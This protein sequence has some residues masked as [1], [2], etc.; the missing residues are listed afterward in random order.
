MN[1]KLER[2]LAELLDAD[3]ITSETAQK[4]STFYGTKEDAK[5]NRLFAI[6]GVLGALLCGLG[7]ILIIA[8]NWDDMPKTMKT[9]LAFI[10]LIIGQIATVYSLIK[11]KNGAWVESS[12]TFLI[13]AAG[14]TI[15]LVSQI[16]NIPGDLSNFLLVW[17]VITAPLIYL[18]RSNLAV[19][20]HL[21]LITCYACNFGY[22]F[23][24]QVPWWYLPLTAWVIPYYIKLQ[25]DNPKSNIAGVLNWL[26]PLSL[27]IV[28]PTFSNGSELVFVMYIGLFGLF[29]NIG[30]LPLFNNQKLRR[31][32]FT[33]IGSLGTVY[34]LTLLTFKWFWTD[35]LHGVI[36]TNDLLISILLFATAI[37]V[38]WYVQM[39]NQLKDFNLFQY[40]FLIFGVLY[41]TK[42]LGSI[43][44]II[45]TNILVAALGLFAVRIGINKNSYGILNYGLLII[46][47]LIACRFF[48]TNLDFV[49][50]GILFIS[51]G[52]GFFFANYLLLKKQRKITSN[53]KATNHE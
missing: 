24:G 15:S 8:H 48:D 17:A 44:G 43:H 21:V 52:A 1:S 26:I 9:V 46:T 29:Y 37:A 40:A 41:L 10:P 39:K 47:A 45:I 14:A 32:G 28:L 31:N 23:G 42:D 51:V 36:S 6:F 16:Y 4:I 7:I 2:Q 22:F 19:I 5:P 50:R 11:K 38:L 20:L 3:I 25:K 49:L 18:L 34:L 27:T 33:I 30:Q 13:L 12:V 53:L 35:S